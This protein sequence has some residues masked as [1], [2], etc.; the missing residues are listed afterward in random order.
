MKRMFDNGKRPDF[1][2]IAKSKGQNVPEVK[3]LNKQSTGTT[4]KIEPKIANNE[5]IDTTK[6]EDWTKLS[7]TE[8]MRRLRG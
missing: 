2:L 6:K 7:R 8:Q 3:N 1:Y 4:Q 5:S